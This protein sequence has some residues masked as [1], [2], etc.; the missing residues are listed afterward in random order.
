MVPTL[1]RA[2]SGSASALTLPEPGSAKG[3]GRARPR[4]KAPACSRRSFVA[5]RLLREQ[6]CGID[7]DDAPFEAERMKNFC[8]RASHRAGTPNIL[9][10]PPG[11][12]FPGAGM[13]IKGS[14]T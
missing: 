1:L 9:G 7:A 5:Q 3:R 8:D 6:A 2:R 12:V 14:L 4:P 13:T 10:N 11:I